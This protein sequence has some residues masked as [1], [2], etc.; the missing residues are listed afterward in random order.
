ML[1]VFCCVCICGCTYRMLEKNNRCRP[2][3]HLKIRK[4]GLI[5]HSYFLQDDDCKFKPALAAAF[6]K[7]VVNI[8]KVSPVVS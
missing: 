6:V 5:E 3:C 8:T 4:D 1:F 2:N 7:E